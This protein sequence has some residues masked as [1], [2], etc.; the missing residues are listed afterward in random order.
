[1][2]RCTSFD[3]VNRPN[4]QALFSN[5]WV[6]TTKKGASK[7][8]TSRNL[9]GFAM[10]ETSHFEQVDYQS[11]KPMKVIKKHFSKETHSKLCENVGIASKSLCICHKIDRL[12]IG[13]IF[14]VDIPYSWPCGLFA[15][16]YSTFPTKPT[17][18]G[19]K[20]SLR[21]F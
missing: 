3:E 18:L 5:K 17:I 4:L 16:G 6:E 12:R 8:L 21:L 11:L 19:L 15:G 20:S 1:M 10:S 2:I 14:P 7:S 13:P 9:T